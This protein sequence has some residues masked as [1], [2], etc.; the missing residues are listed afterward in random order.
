MIRKITSL[1]IVIAIYISLVCRFSREEVTVDKI[2]EKRFENHPF[3]KYK[4]EKICM[5]KLLLNYI[6]D[7]SNWPTRTVKIKEDIGNENGTENKKCKEIKITVLPYI[8]DW[9]QVSILLAYSI[10]NIL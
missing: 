5:Y 1:S 10:C 4:S 9:E 6:T 2:I 3:K 7:K 8:K